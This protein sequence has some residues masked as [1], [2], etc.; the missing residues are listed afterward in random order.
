MPNDYYDDGAPPDQTSMP[1]KSD[2]PEQEEENRDSEQTTLIPSS[3]CP[4]MDVGDEIVLKIVAT[5]EDEYEVAYA[6]K[7]GKHERE[8]SMAEASEENETGMHRGGM[9]SY[10]D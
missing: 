3:L 1:A 6:P 2:T 5:H 10:M 4:G 9:G 8:P 7:K